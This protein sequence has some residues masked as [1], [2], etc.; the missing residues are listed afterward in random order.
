MTPTP[1][2]PPGFTGDPNVVSPGVIG[3]IVIFLIAAATV[4][5]VVDM[6]RRIRRVRYRDE[7]RERIA[8][9][10]AEQAEQAPG[11]NTATAESNEPT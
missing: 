5:L 3:F 10:Q 8:Q 2:L 6:T 9:E 11:D 4:L 1:T 7:A